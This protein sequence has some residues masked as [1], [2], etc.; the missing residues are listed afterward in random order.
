MP[1]E[2]LTRRLRAHLDPIGREAFAPG[3]DPWLVEPSGPD[4]VLAAAEAMA[5]DTPTPRDPRWREF[6]SRLCRELLQAA[7]EEGGWAIAGALVVLT[8]LD[9]A[10]RSTPGCELLDEATDFLR[11]HGVA[12]QQW[13]DAARTRWIAR[14]GWPPT[15]QR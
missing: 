5:L 10:R 4:I 1:H 8:A 7:R 12:L 14:H 11:A 2:L 15:I 6:E 3:G 13:P 9:G